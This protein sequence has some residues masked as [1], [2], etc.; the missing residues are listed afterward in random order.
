MTA[1]VFCGIIA[2]TEPAVIVRQWPDAIAFIPLRPV[3]RG[4]S[5]VVPRVHVPDAVTNPAVT[6]LTMG[7]AA[8]LAAAYS[9]SNIVTSV[10][11]AATQSVFHLHLHVIPREA[12]DRLML[13]WSTL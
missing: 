5:L 4:H 10:G 11:S 2:G 13:P 9:A 7:R 3:V 1:C 6:A 12:G 8:E